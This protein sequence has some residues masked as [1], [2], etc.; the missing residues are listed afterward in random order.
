MYSNRMNFTRQ[1]FQYDVDT[2]FFFSGGARGHIVDDIKT[3]LSEGVPLVMLTGT[4][5][6]GKTMICRKVEQDL[7]E[8]YQILFFEQGVESFDEV[9]EGIS[10]LVATD[11]DDRTADRNLRLKGIAEKLKQEKRRLIVIID[12]AESIFLATLER[13]RK[14]VD[15]ANGEGTTIQLVLSGQPLFLLN[16]KQLG[17]VP[18]QDIEERNYSLDPLDAEITYEYLNHCIEIAAGSAQDFFSPRMADR[19]MDTARGNFRLINR[20]ADRYVS[21]GSLM[22]PE[23]DGFDETQADDEPVGSVEENG[24]I[25]ASAG[26]G[27]VDLDFLKVPRLKY[28]WYVVA[29]GIVGLMLIAFLLIGGDDEPA[30]SGSETEIVPDLTLDK[31][32]PDPIEIPE[33]VE[34]SRPPIITRNDKTAVESAVETVVEKEEETPQNV[35]EKT[36]SS[37]VTEE[38]RTENVQEREVS[39]PPPI[40][41]PETVETAEMSPREEGLESDAGEEPEMKRVVEN[42]SAT[43]SEQADTEIPIEFAAVEEQ[44]QGTS[45]EQNIEPV[46]EPEL[47]DEPI[48]VKSESV[49]SETAMPSEPDVEDSLTEPVERVPAQDDEDRDVPADLQEPTIAEETTQPEPADTAARNEPAEPTGPDTAVIVE[50][51]EVPAPPQL[52]ETQKDQENVVSAES[53]QIPELTVVTKK[54]Q[55]TETVPFTVVT[56]RDERKRLPGVQAPAPVPKPKLVAQ[57]SEQQ[58]PV[59]IKRKE[60]KAAAPPAPSQTEPV[61][62]QKPVPTAPSQTEPVAAQKPVSPAPSAPLTRSTA[63]SQNPRVHYAERLAAGSRWLVG[64]GSGKYTVQLMVLHSD[65]AEKNIGEML[66]EAGYQPIKNQTYILRKAGQTQTVTLYFGEFDSQEEARQAQKQLPQFLKD[67]NP[68]AVSVNDAVNKAKNVQ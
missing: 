37:V 52:P 22:D 55:R 62:A 57:S 23:V 15:L 43:Q 2:A 13:I 51:V 33:T 11:Q 27:N 64:G 8:A 48:V 3:A 60:E 54:K 45:L 16:F 65:L 50:T 38:Q 56:L 5:G 47:V 10:A 49:A 66:N 21:S 35:P 28:R 53:I 32:E 67:L 24:R 46:K 29:G 30:E 61:A 40:I 34:Q 9:I 39:P 63:K 44:E 4:D 6:S 31:V 20:L 58:Q 14:M 19:I 17:I 7:G 41:T 25:H 1:P 59:A 18:F 42:E 12:G 68:Y 26:L 36:D